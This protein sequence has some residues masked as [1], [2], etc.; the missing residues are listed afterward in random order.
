M[1]YANT[2]R[3]NK[4]QI[5]YPHANQ[6]IVMDNIK[7]IHLEEYLLELQNIINPQKIHSASRMSNKIYIFF[8]DKQ[9]TDNFTEKYKSINVLNN[10]IEIKRYTDYTKRI[11]ISNC[12]PMIP[13]SVIEQ[14]LI[15]LSIHLAS[16]INILRIGTRYDAF[17]HIL[18]S[19]RQTYIIPNDNVVLPESLNIEYNNKTY[20]IYLME[21]SLR[22]SNC[23]KH[24]HNEDVCHQ[25]AKE[26]DERTT[27]TENSPSTSGIQNLAQTYI[28]TTLSQG[29]SNFVNN[30]PP[31]I[32]PQTE[33]N[34]ELINTNTSVKETEQIKQTP[35]TEIQ[36][37]LHQMTKRQLEEQYKE[38]SSRMELLRQQM[39]EEEDND[40]EE[41]Q[42]EEIELTNTLETATP[43]Q[44]IKRPAESSHNSEENLSYTETTASDD[45]VRTKHKKP[46]SLTPKLTIEQQMENI[47]IDI[48]E[49]PQNYALS[50]D[51][52]KDFLENTPGHK[53]IL[54]LAQEYTSDIPQLITTLN[55]LYKN[56]Y[57]NKLKNRVTRILKKLKNGDYIMEH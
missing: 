35:S 9:T 13:N 19:R 10:I 20:K 47:R 48:E 12:L 46:K 37:N 31:P 25:A 44:P 52:L 45:E 3:N 57:N 15:E 2:V 22:C 23:F 28:E 17:K 34:N 4:K 11:I 6:G 40:E 42:D 21:D 50:F 30:Q 5:N 29:I 41:S 16:S 38:L 56:L 51:Q 36:T 26:S 27:L 33:V 14:K 32:Q 8:I 7:E 24:G 18:S 53:N 43:H 1:T 55:R 39:N 54:S 49:N